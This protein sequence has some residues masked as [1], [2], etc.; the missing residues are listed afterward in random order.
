ME[1]ST[2]PE[3]T[4]QLLIRSLQ[5]YKATFVRVFYLGFLLSLV[6]FTPRLITFVL[7][8][9]IFKNLAINSPHQL[10]ILVIDLISLIFFTSILWRMRCESKNIHEPVINDFKIALKKLPFI[11]LTAILQSII[12]TIISLT[13]FTLFLFLPKESLLAPSSNT[14]SLITLTFLVQSALAVYIFMLFYFYLPII[15]TENKRVF[16][17]LKESAYL[18]WGNWWKTI[19][20]QI[21]PWLLYIITLFILREIMHINLHIFFVPSAEEYTLSGTFLNIL[22]FAAFIPW[23]AAT[24]LVQL[25]DLE[26]RKKLIPS[27]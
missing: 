2:Q 1:L 20:L 27:T 6:I 24:Q 9:D 19:K 7:G 17:S 11:V 23:F 26:L 18:V 21:I 14:L 15:L 22:V 25:R 13:L 4:K 5:L 3:S 8:K 16:G 12:I 10:W